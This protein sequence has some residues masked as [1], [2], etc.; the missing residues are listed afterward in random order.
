MEVILL[1]DVASLGS[2]GDQVKV[3]PGYARNFLLPKKMAIPASTK[4]QKRLEH[5]KRLAAHRL[6]QAKKDAEALVAKLKGVSVSIARKVGEQDKLYGSVTAH[7]IQRAL[8]DAGV[9]V[10]RRK[11][12]LD[13]PLKALGEFKVPVRI[14][15]DL[16][17][18]I[19][20]AVVAEE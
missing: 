17:A 19:T 2:I 12:V 1:E 13:E 11:L 18:E 9:D 8:T 16:L 15:E 3:K 6:S 4:N 14:R 20:V 10:D 5:E 7:D